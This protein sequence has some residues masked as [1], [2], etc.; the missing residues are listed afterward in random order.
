MQIQQKLAFKGVKRQTPQRDLI[1]AIL[2][3]A[4]G[5]LSAAQICQMAREKMPN[6]GL[7]TLYR[8]LKNLQESGLVRLVSLPD[9]LPRYEKSGLGQHHFQ[10]R[11]CQQIWTIKHSSLGPLNEFRLEGGFVVEEHNSTFYGSCPQCKK[12]RA[13]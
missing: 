13:A 10:S 12:S 7:A 9:G 3:G 8:A 1:L 2:R 5:P 4:G 6:L 11:G